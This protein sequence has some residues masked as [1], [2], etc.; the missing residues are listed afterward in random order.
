MKLAQRIG[1]IKP[2]PT[3]AITAKANALRAEGL[4]YAVSN[5]FT[6]SDQWFVQCD[7]HD[8]NWIWD[9]QPRGSMDEDFDAEFIKRKLV[10]G[11]VAGHGEWYGTWA[12]TGA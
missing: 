12:S 3:L 8:C 9:V 10:Q 4:S 6:D 7:V 5:Y 11:Y 2:S 1:R